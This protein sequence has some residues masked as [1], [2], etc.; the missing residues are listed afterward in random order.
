MFHNV[1]KGAAAIAVVSASVLSAAPAE[2]FPKLSFEDW[3]Y[4]NSYVQEERVP[5]TN[6]ELQQA[7]ADSL[8]LRNGADPLE[9]FFINE[10]AGFRNQLLFSANGGPLQMIF[11]DVSSPDSILRNSDG[12]LSLGEG[13]NLGTF[14]AG[15]RI[16]FFINSNGFSRGENETNATRLLGP[17]ASQNPHGVQHMI[18]YSMGEWTFFGFEDIIGGG[19]RDYN[20]VVFVARGLAAT[21]IPEPT[22]VLSLLGL[23]V[24]G[25]AATRRQQQA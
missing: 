2:A 11:E 12:P 13:R 20:D 6:L 21:P 1:A 22:A 23:G 24:M 10:G 7:Q 15:T 14:A 8:L 19:D 25:L 9:V 5:F 17:D 16:D 3:S 4:F 18:A